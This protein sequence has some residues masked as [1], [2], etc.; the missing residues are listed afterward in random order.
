MNGKGSKQRPTNHAKYGKNYEKVFRKSINN[1]HVDDM[2]GV[3]KIETEAS[4]R[5]QERKV[6]IVKEYTDQNGVDMV[7]V[8]INDSFT[9][10]TIP[11]QLLQ[12]MDRELINQDNPYPVLEDTK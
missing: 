3:I 9:N 4:G 12:T 6:K 8:N 11:K 5:R 7:I 2:T 1:A 10:K